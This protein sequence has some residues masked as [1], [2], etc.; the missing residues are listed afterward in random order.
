MAITHTWEVNTCE[1]EL[2]DGYVK[3]VIYRIKSADDSTPAVTYRTTGNV[4]L[5]KPGTLVPYTDLT[6]DQVIGWVKAKLDA[7]SSGTTAALEANAEAKFNAEK[8]PVTAT[9]K[10]W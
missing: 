9:G 5:P 10:P 1:R 2:A 6:H 4:D 7:D 3:N 8:T